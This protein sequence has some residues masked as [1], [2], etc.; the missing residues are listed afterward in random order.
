M[1]ME[2]ITLTKTEAAILRHRLEAPDCIAEALEEEARSDNNSDEVF[3]IC[4]GLLSGLSDSGLSFEGVAG[5]NE[6]KVKAVIADAVNGSTWIG[7]MIGEVSDSKIR[8]NIR[9]GEKLAEKVSKLIGEE[10][11]LPTW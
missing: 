5:M 6:E 1:T 10:V 2:A 11:S 3:D 4:K 8:A 7:T 9:A